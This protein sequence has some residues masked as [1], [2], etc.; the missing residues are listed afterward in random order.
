MTPS[1]A[2]TVAISWPAPKATDVPLR[3]GIVAAVPAGPFCAICHEP[4]RAL[5][6]RKYCLTCRGPIA[7]EW[8]KKS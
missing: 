4:I 8:S 1:T 2:G 6:P 5:V 7:N 3:A